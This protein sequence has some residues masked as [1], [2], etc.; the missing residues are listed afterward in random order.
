MGGFHR[1]T[2]AWLAVW[3][4]AATAACGHV[5]ALEKGLFT[6]SDVHYW[7][8]DVPPHWKLF[9]LR[10][11]DLA[12]QSEDS[13]HWMAVN[14][15]CRDYEDAP[16]PVLT[17]HLLMGFTERRLIEEKTRTLDGR[18]ALDSR[19]VAKLNGVP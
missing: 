6:K 18:E 19:Y 15:T 17:R 1:A 14:S 11:N 7:I 16:L 13:E 5:G 2:R 3:A 10:G 9:N 12:Y 4:S 8:G